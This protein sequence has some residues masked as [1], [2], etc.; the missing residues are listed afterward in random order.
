MQAPQRILSWRQPAARGTGRATYM[1][2]GMKMDGRSLLSRKLH[3]ASKMA[4][5]T[6]KMVSVAAY[7]SDFGLMPRSRSRWAILAL[8]MLVR[9]RKQTR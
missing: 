6:K 5:D 4:Y 9:S 8:P 3:R 2:M 1:M 7:W